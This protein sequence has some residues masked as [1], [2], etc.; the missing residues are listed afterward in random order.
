MKIYTVAQM[1]DAELR[2]GTEYGISLSALMDNAGNSLA[3]VALDMKP[4][5]SV[6]IFCGK[7]N[8]GGD[9]YVCATVL[10]RHGLHVEVWG[11]GRDDLSSDSLVGAAADAFETAGGVIRPFTTETEIS[12]DCGLIIDAL[13][14][15]GLERPLGGL[16][17]HAVNIIN[18][19]S[20]P[21]LSC[22]LPSGVDADTGRIMG[23]AIHANK[24]LMLGLAKQACSLPPGKECFGELIL[25]DIGLPRELVAQYEP[26]ALWPH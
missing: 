14:G 17:V 2:A 22:D 10:L 12:A 11:I 23:I 13:F 6:S 15:T 24:T 7:G 8:N 1:R 4:R 16:Y 19:A 21:V 3:Q 20:V 5:G 26:V 9:G 18:A 25:G